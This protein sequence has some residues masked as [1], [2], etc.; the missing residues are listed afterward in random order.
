[1]SRAP[2]SSELLRQQK[3]QQH[4]KSRESYFVRLPPSR[5]V[6]S[7]WDWHLLISC[8]ETRAGLPFLVVSFAQHCKCL[9]FWSRTRWAVLSLPIQTRTSRPCAN[10]CSAR[11]WA[12]LQRQVG[13]PTPAGSRITSS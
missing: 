10:S 2:W 3:Q 13:W 9:F 12:G 8:E 4:G 1:V 5:Q 6:P 11:A 7:C